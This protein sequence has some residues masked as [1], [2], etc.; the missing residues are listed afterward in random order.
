MVGFFIVL[1]VFK[2]NSFAAATIGV[3]SGQKVIAT[4]PYAI[5]RHPMY[6]GALVLLIGT[7]LALG[8][9]WGILAVIPMTLVLALRLL[10]E[11]KFLSKSL[12]GYEEYCQKVRSRLAPSIW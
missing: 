6:A 8:S 7:P 4:G 5:V 2:E 10:D 1:L 12:P 11:E 9:W 3:A